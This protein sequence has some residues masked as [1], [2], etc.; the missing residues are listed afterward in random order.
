MSDNPDAFLLLQLRWLGLEEDYD[1]VNYVDNDVREE[2]RKEVQD[3]L[4]DAIVKYESETIVGLESLKTILENL[5]HKRTD[6]YD[7][8]IDFI[9]IIYASGN[10][11]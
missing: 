7:L 5:K 4:Y 9:V 10:G 3:K 6:P 1:I 11:N 8:S 2:I